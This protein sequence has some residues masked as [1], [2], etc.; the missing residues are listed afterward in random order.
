MTSIL[1]LL[2]AFG[3]FL[4]GMLV[5]AIFAMQDNKK[6]NDVKAYLGEVG[7]GAMVVLFAALLWLPIAFIVALALL[8]AAIVFVV[9][10]SRKEKRKRRQMPAGDLKD[11]IGEDVTIACDGTT[12]RMDYWLARNREKRTFVVNCT[13]PDSL[14]E[15][16][17]VSIDADYVYSKMHRKLVSVTSH[18]QGA[19]RI[20]SLRFDRHTGAEIKLWA[21]N[22][23]PEH[24]ELQELR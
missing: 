10:L 3:V 8:P 23:D 16:P 5:V 7:E 12:V 6:S 13:L 20:Y 15:D 19:C 2:I 24:L 22:V 11:Y 9:W 14:S 21:K 17:E 4:V 1:Y 18:T